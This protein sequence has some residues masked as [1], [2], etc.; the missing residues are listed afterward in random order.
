M[1]M[2]DW[3]DWEGQAA[4]TI[5]Q[6]RREVDQNKNEMSIIQISQSCRGGEHLSIPQMSSSLSSSWEGL[7][8]PGIRIAAAR[9]SCAFC[10]ASV[11]FS[12]R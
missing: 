10:A 1:A 9:S 4:K 3:G 2:G 8:I 12:S 11:S 6:K 7:S 5:S